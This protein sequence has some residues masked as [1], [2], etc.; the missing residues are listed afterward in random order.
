[1]PDP[2][3][4]WDG[5]PQDRVEAF[6]RPFVMAFRDRVSSVQLDIACPICGVPQ[7]R[8]YWRLYRRSAPTADDDGNVFVGRGGHWEW[9]AA[10]GA[11]EHSSA[12]VPDWWSGHDVL[13]QVPMD[14][15]FHDPGTLEA[16]LRSSRS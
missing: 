10:C 14:R 13:D 1:M 4:A 9:C 5:V 11:Y 3:P 16:A 2:S 8:W 6:H 15:L 7:L 12:A